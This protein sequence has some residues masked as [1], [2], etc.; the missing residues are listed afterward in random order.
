V[1][2]VVAEMNNNRSI[3]CFGIPISTEGQAIFEEIN[4]K[5]IGALTASRLNIHSNT[6]GENITGDEFGSDCKYLTVTFASL[7]AADKL[8]EMGLEIQKQPVLLLPIM[9]EVDFSNIT[10][11]HLRGNASIPPSNDKCHRCHN[12]DPTSGN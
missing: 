7:S 12:R 4:R 5:N 1:Q 3:Y 8:L 2:P 10:I 6:F 11:A 9:T